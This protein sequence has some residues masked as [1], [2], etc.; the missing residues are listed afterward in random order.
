[1]TVCADESE[2]SSPLHRVDPLVAY[3]HRPV[4]YFFQGTDLFDI[5][6]GRVARPQ[7]GNGTQR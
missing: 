1:M 6:D 3:N 5:N 2:T 7:L 4:H